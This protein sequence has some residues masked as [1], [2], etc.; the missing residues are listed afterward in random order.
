SGGTLNANYYALRHL[1]AAGLSLSG[2]PTVTSLSYGDF[3]LYTNGGSMMTVASSTIDANASKQIDSVRFSTSTGVTSGANVTLSGT[4][5]GAWNF[6]AHYGNYDG[7]VYDS[8]GVDSCGFIRWDDSSCLFVSQEHFRFRN[9]DGGEGAPDSEWYNT[10]WS[11]RKKVAITNNTATTYTNTPVKIVVDYDADMQS[12]F[13]D[14]R[15]TDT[16]GTTSISYWIEDRVASASSTVWVNVASLPASGSSYVYMYYGNG[17]VGDA[18]DGDATLGFFDDFEDDN[19]SE[20]SGN[21]S[22]FDVDTTFNNTGSYGLDAGTNADLITTSGIYRTGSLLQQGKT[23]RYFQYVDSSFDDE[24]CTLFGVQGAGDNY[25]V[26]LDQYPSDKLILAE[27]VESND[28]SGTVLAS[29]TVSYSTGWYEV[30]VDWRSGNV[31]YVSV[32][33][34]SG[35]EFA[36]TTATDSSKSS[37]GV[38]FSFWGQHGGWDTVMSYDY[39]A[40]RPSTVF[41]TEQGRSGASWY[42]AEDTSIGGVEIGE[43][44]RLRFSVLNSGAALFGQFFRLQY[45][46]KGVSASCEAVPSVN[47]NDVPAAGGGCG[48]SPA[49]IVSSTQFADGTPSTPLLTYPGAYAFAAGGMVE[50]PS[51]QTASTSVPTNAATEVEYVFELT[52]QATADAYCFRTS[53]GG[54]ELDNYERVPQISLT[55]PPVLSAFNLNNDLPIGLTEG[56]TT[57]IYATSTVTDNNGF[58]DILFATSSIYRSVVGPL[59]S[60]DNNNC[61]QIASTSCSLTNCSGNSCRVQCAADIQYFADPTD[62][63]AFSAQNWLAGI[64]VEDSTGLRDTQTT[65]GVELL[66]LQ[67]LSVTAAIDY[68]SLE[69]GSTTGATNQQTTVLNTGNANIDIQLEGTSLTGTGSSIPVGEQKFATTTFSYSACSICQ[70]L[71]GTA[72][73]FEVDLPKPTST[74]TP[75]A[76][77]VYWGINVPTGTK[78]VPHSGTNTFWATTD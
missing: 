45:A 54:L 65:P 46:P 73:T 30:N 26:C 48:S 74:S 62:T 68:G 42:A 60:A 20:Y 49:C 57:T 51:N 78:A 72:T 12:D 76:D 47:Y 70:F 59:C 28:G 24:P 21:T 13:D 43:D 27:D 66:T 7:E 34:A 5:V 25:A 8:D 15:F 35:A 58:A 3:E 4:P 14:L 52:S 40:T 77:D 9:D 2:T 17:A 50:S 32:Y 31:I 16:S 63:G 1:N 36:T 37:G 23:L 41:G 53:N 61:Y 39:M 75:S 38:G 19:I 67:A 64:S 55:F 56:A 33:D 11:K 69:V 29:T 71:T 22:L 18:S 10:S 44:I 6:N